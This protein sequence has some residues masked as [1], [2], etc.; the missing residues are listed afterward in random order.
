MQ[1]KKNTKYPI[2]GITIIIC[3]IGIIFFRT[4]PFPPPNFE[5]EKYQRTCLDLKGF[6]AMLNRFKEQN[7]TLPNSGESL[8]VLYSN[9][10]PTK[11]PNYQQITKK[12]VNGY[13]NDPW[14]NPYYY[15]N[16]KDS[17][18]VFSFG[19]DGK[20]GGVEEAKD[21]FIGSCPP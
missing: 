9:P 10:D 6:G 18:E 12:P 14:G 20:S 16:T 8:Q 7:D 1:K 17:F 19:S 13:F 3:I 21:I 15:I 5:V 11:Y 4:T 2:V